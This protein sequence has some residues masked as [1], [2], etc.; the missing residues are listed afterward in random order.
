LGCAATAALLAGCAGNP[1]AEAKVDANS[2][3]AEDVARMAHESRDFPTFADIPPPPSAQR[4]LASWGQAADQLEV[5][6]ANVEAATAPSTWTLTGT[7]RFVA[8]ARSQVGPDIGPIEST[9]PSSE[10]FAKELRERA[11]PP[12]SP[13]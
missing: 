9:T 7:E 8:R 12:P 10:A 2:A 6:R 5:A 13:R 3:V 11:T 4:P 1:F